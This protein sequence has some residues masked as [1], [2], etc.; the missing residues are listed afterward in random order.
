[1]VFREGHSTELA[2][3]E[4]VD[5]IIQEMD[6]GE[7]PFNV[8]LD[9]SKAFDT[10]DHAILLHKLEYYGI[11][12]NELKLCNSYLTDCKQFVDIED[13]KSEM[14]EIKKGVPQRSVLGPLLFIIYMNDISLASKLF[15]LIIYDDDSTQISIHVHST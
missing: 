6:K 12:D 13:T 7:K 8:Y 11:K 9:L 1:M 2:A 3:L 4:L 5:I 15:K 14:L 10:L